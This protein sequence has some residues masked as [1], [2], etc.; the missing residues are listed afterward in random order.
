M[1]PTGIGRGQHR[2]ARRKGDADEADPD[3][4]KARREHRRAEH[5][6]DQPE[7]AEELGRKFPYHDANVPLDCSRAVKG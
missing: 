6:K 1:P 2:D 3:I 7:G 4:G 5:R